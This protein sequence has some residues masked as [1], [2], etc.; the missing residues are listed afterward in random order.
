MASQLFQLLATVRSP[1]T[2]DEHQYHSSGAEYVCEL[3]LS[4][5]TGLQRKRWGPVSNAEAPH[6]SRH[7]CSST[8]DSRLLQVI[9]RSL[10][11]VIQPVKASTLRPWPAHC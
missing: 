11:Y 8:F 7:P 5:V 9:V 3:H 4:T 2:A 10:S 6:G 1:G